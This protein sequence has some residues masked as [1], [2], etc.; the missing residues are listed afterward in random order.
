[1][2]KLFTPLA[3][4]SPYLLVFSQL[5]TVFIF[6]L[7][8]VNKWRDFDEFVQA[9]ENFQILP[10]S[11]AKPTAQFFVIGELMILIMMILG[12][13]FLLPGFFLALM[14]LVVFTTGLISI[15]VRKIP[16]SCYCFVTTTELVT[17][18]TVWRNMG[19]I[20]CVLAGLCSL[21]IQ[22]TILSNLNMI[23]QWLL[24]MMAITFVV[25]CGYVGEIV[26]LIRTI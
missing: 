8:S 7:S 21:F 13:Q 3:E 9:V 17:I 19:F 16:T 15:L 25:V 1:M 2:H 6:T 11:Q 4:L 26:G 12:G 20:I 23:E 10:S 18:Y 22:P 5:A 24:G 14:L